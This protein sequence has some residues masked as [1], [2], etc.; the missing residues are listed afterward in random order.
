MTID[1]VI[2]CNGSGRSSG[3]TG[4]AAP[5]YAQKFAFMAKAEE[6]HVAINP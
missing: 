5:Y 3:I 6:A 2:S 1:V 4:A